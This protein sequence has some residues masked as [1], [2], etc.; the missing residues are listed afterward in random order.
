MKKNTGGTKM[1]RIS[2]FLL[3]VIMLFSV[4]GRAMAYFEDGHLIRVVYSGAGTGM[5]TATDLGLI[6]DWTSVSTAN[7]NFNAP[8]FDLSLLGAG[9]NETNSFIAYFAVTLTPNPKNQAWVGGTDAAQIA[10][11]ANFGGYAG[12]LHTATGLYQVTGNGDGSVQ[13]VTVSQTDPNSFWNTLNNGGAGVGKMA[14]FVTG[15]PG[16]GV[17][18]LNGLGAN[19]HVDMNLFYYGAPSG[20]SGTATG[21]NVATVRTYADGHT[22][23]NPDQQCVPSQEVCDGVDND[24]D[25]Q[26]DERNRGTIR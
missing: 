23:L 16:T 18:G 4:S 17:G 19:G 3:A 1:K 14:G 11:K 6:S 15:T 12:K 10:S 20:I 21:L 2:I 24:C 5:E 8:A 13:Q 26:I 22:E 25:G 9:A 7:H